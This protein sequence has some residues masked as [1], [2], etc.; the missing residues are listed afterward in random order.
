[1]LS[2]IFAVITGVL[3]GV[4][5]YAN[6][7]THVSAYLTAAAVVVFAATLFGLIDYYGE[8]ILIRLDNIEK[9]HE[10]SGINA[11]K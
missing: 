5:T 8:R 10:N 3:V 2:Y 1:M 6:G 4:G 9:A 7:A 11:H